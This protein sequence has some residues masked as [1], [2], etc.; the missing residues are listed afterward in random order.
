MPEKIILEK[1][2]PEL[3]QLEEMLV[4]VEPSLPAVIENS[5]YYARLKYALFPEIYSF[6]REKTELRDDLNILRLNVGEPMSEDKIRDY[7]DAMMEHYNDSENNI[8]I[9][10]HLE[11][12]RI[13]YGLA[14]FAVIKRDEIYMKKFVFRFRKNLADGINGLSNAGVPISQTQSTEGD[15]QD[16]VDPNDAMSKRRKAFSDLDKKTRGPANQ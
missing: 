16:N 10:Y 13:D 15:S 4:H 3:K 1:A 8:G 6:C 11:I 9:D 5:V 14:V 12:T 7:M 2:S